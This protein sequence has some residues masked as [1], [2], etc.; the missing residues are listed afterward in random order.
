M[1]VLTNKISHPSRVDPSELFASI[2]RSPKSNSVTFPPSGSTASSG[3]AMVFHEG[4]VSNFPDFLTRKSFD[5]LL[6]MFLKLGADD[7]LLATGIPLTIKLNGSWVQVSDRPISYD[8]VSL[9]AN[10][11]DNST[12][13]SR[14]MSGQ[15]LQFAHAIRSASEQYRFRVNG[16]RIMGVGGTDQAA[17]LTLRTIPGT[18]PSVEELG[19]PPQILAMTQHRA[20]LFVVSGPT[21]SGKTTTSA[22][23]LRDVIE[24]RQGKNIV[25]FE[26]PIEFVYDKL[27]KKSVVQQSEVKWLEG[28]W[29]DVG[30]NLLRRNPD[31]AFLGEAPDKD[32]MEAAVKFAAHGKFVMVTLHANSVAG[33][34]GRMADEWPVTSRSAILKSIVANIR[35]I[36]HQRLVKAPDTDARTPIFGML[37]FSQDM[38]EHLGSLDS[39]ELLGAITSYVKTHG[40]SELSY[41]QA[42]FNEGLIHPEDF[43]VLKKEFEI[44]D[45]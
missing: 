38:R 35:G 41:A 39:E 40:V 17:S 36:V 33:T 6:L 14:M 24:T 7:T 34:I 13:Q 4:S 19:L 20:G 2:G 44:N 15:F 25:T 1:A 16:T 9:I 23:L 18:P 42:K 10:E 29:S 32:A 5:E 21:G 45:S 11:I 8:E 31:I 3:S 28:R 37:E 12:A 26:D 43:S 22:A 30:P 27:E